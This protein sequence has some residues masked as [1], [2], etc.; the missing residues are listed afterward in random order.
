MVRMKLLTIFFHFFVVAVVS[1]IM[2]PKLPTQDNPAYF[3]FADKMGDVISN[4]GFVGVGLMGLSRSYDLAR[5]IFSIGVFLT[6][7][8]SAYFHWNPTP[9]TLFWDR[10]PMAISFAGMIC[11]ITEDRLFN[12]GKILIIFV[13]TASIFTVINWAF[14]NHD[15]R[16]YILLQFV[17]SF[18]VLFVCVCT[19]QDA[20]K[21]RYVYYSVFFYALAKACEFYDREILALTTVI[22]GH[23]LKH[24]SAAIAAFFFLP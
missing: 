3:Q 12:L 4:L 11:M 2:W 9:D 16:P 1:I 24:I 17:G 15:L 21:N 7:L 13:T 6:G 20:I 8:G 18:Y 22:S 14:G 10:L 23:T 5:I 19:K